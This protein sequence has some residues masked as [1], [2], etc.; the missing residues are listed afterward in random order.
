MLSQYLLA[1]NLLM[2]FKVCINYYH[3]IVTPIDGVDSGK[4]LKI[5]NL[6]LVRPVVLIH[7]PEGGNQRDF[8]AVRQ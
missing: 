2:T 4:N 3:R 6:P 7:R 8:N 1:N 5:K